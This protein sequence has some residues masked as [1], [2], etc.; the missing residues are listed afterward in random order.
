M[1]YSNGGRTV[2]FRAF[3]QIENNRKKDEGE[4]TS[5]DKNY[6]YQWHELRTL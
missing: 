5:Y 3:S 4:K 6:E 2:G 1:S